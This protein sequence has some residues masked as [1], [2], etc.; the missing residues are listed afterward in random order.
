MVLPPEDQRGLARY[1]VIYFAGP[2]DATLLRPVESA[3]LER[4][5][6][7]VE[8]D[9]KRAMPPEGVTAGEWV[10][11]RFGSIDRNYASNRDNG[12]VVK[13]VEVASYA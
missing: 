5:D 6:G 7:E 12:V 3:L 9:E 2:D 8:G 11:V 1:G 4:M 13:R 10:R